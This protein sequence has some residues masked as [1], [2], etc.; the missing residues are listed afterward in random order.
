MTKTTETEWHY[1]G[2]HSVRFE[3]P[4]ILFSRPDGD[5]S[6]AELKALIAF[7]E[8]LPR[9]EKGFFGLLDVSKGGRQDPAA[10]SLP[11]AREHTRHQ[12]AIVYFNTKFYHRTLIGMFQRVAKILNLGPRDL[13]VKVFDTEAEARAW[14]EEFRKNDA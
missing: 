13:P 10:M 5:M 11:E 9:P 4:D 7:A 6:V 1:I 2:K 12:R 8:S 3:P 14:I